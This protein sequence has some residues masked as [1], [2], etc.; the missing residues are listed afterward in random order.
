M[1]TVN[2]NT[3]TSV[4]RDEN[5]WAM[6][7]HFSVF[8]VFFIPF[9]NIIS[10]LII[11]LIKKDELPFVDDQGKEVV[12]FQITL[13]IY[14]IA[15]TI[16]SFLLVGIPLLIG[17]L[18]FGFIVTIIAAMKANDGEKYRYPMNIRFID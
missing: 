11:W 15:S 12:N 8:T 16:L 7:C 9:G 13:T 1:N 6:L 2:S 10:P 3:A 5:M 4:N 17:L 14:L 18:I